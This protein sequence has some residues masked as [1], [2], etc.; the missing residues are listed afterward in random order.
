MYYAL[1]EGG[2]VKKGMIL[3]L[4]ALTTTLFAAD[5]PQYRGLNRDGVSKETGLLKS[6]PAS[7]PRVVWRTPVGEGYSSLAVVGSR[8]YTMDADGKNE[9]VIAFDSATGKN[10]WR[11]QIDSEYFNGQGNGPRSTPSV[12]GNWLYAVGANGKLVALS[13]SNGKMIWSH[14]LVK[15]FAS[16][17]PSWGASTSPLIEGDLV[18]V[19]VGGK[20]GY[21]LVA[22]N[23]KDGSVVWKAFTDRQGYSSPIAATIGGVRQII[24]FS[25]TSLVSVS[26]QGKVYWKYPWRTSYDAN[27]A[28]PLFIPPDKIFISTGYDVGAAVLKITVADGTP[29][30]KEIWKSKVM[31]NH[32]NSSVH[33]QGHIY[34]FDNAI[35]KCIDPNNGTEKWK[36]SGF[37][38]GSL[39]LAD[40]NLI[41][42]GDAGQ[43]AMVEATPT[44]YKEIAKVP[45]MRGKTW[46]M[47]ALADGKL[48][49]R[50]QKEIAVYDLTA[51]K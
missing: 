37:G 24:L 25:G 29:D 45:A 20:S 14:D 43:L 15:E 40:E 36:V 51:A 47:P 35:L 39:I 2:F 13:T 6:W 44:A 26:V 19:N 23:K 18:L 22:F 28:T 5:W 48:Y 49:L 42:L 50:S 4:L 27:I 38:K 33:H 7:G 46:T 31:Q 12:E 9:F 41:V 1:P 10:L 16:E 34:G 11:T 3:F 21:A 8:V 30:F 17:I 32:F